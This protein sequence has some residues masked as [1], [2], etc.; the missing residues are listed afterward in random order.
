[1]LTR[2][3]GADAKLWNRR[4]RL[5]FLATE[6]LFGYAGGAVWGVSHYRLAPA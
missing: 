2:V 4:W 6:G 5:F 1:V 3:Y